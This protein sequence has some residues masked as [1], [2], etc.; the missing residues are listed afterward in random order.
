MPSR[1][2]GCGA[3]SPSRPDSAA[4]KSYNRQ[5]PH[6]KVRHYVTFGLSV[7]GYVALWATGVNSASRASGRSPRPCCWRLLPTYWGHSQFNSKDS[8][9]ASAF[10]IAMWSASLAMPGPAGDGT[11]P[12]EAL[13]ALCSFRGD[14]RVR[15][16]GTSGGW[17][18]T[19]RRLA[20]GRMDPRRAVVR[21][22]RVLG[23]PVGRRA[24]RPPR[25]CWCWPALWA[26]PLPRLL[27][28]ARTAGRFP[29]PETVLFWGAEIAT[30]EHP[31]LL[32]AG[33]AGGQAAGGAGRSRRNRSGRG[34]VR[35]PVRHSRNERAFASFSC[36]SSCPPR[37]LP[38]F[39]SGSTTTK[40]TCSSSCPAWRS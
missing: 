28:A 20:G 23:A 27:S 34:A 25:P 37:T 21:D 35:T 1:T 39:T 3:S 4:L 9:F 8:G 38:F 26:D 22:R 5:F 15:H 14:D 2:L 16:R 11:E 13:R 18:D 17:A 24:S 31:V 19:R 33:R 36:G 12:A 10:V 32:R 6:F 40:G 29:G 30:R 7:V